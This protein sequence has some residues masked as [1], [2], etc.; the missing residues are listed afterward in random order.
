[1]FDQSVIHGQSIPTPLVDPHFLTDRTMTYRYIRADPL[2][3]NKNS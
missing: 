1:M 2:I 3:L